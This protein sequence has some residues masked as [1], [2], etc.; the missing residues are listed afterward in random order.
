MF[1]NACNTGGCSPYT[2]LGSTLT[3]TAV[4]TVVARAEGG[5]SV[6]LSISANS[7][8]AGTV[9]AVEQSSG[10]DAN[11]ARILTGTALT[12]TVTDLTPGT[13]YRFRVV[14]INSAGVESAPSA[15]A[16]ATPGNFS[17][18]TVRAYPVP[19][20]PGHGVDVMTFDQVPAGATIK[21]YTMAGQLVKSMTATD[22][23]VPWDVRNDGGESVASGVYVVRVEGAGGN[24]MF[25]IVIQ[26]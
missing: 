7:N 23:S 20:R 11:Y 10:S 25:K 24:K 5:T 9:Y 14:S 2:L 12:V 8:P 17:A 18:Q 16:S 15:V 21:V 3:L 26:R 1:V 4:P 19:F 13:A 6:V 22:T